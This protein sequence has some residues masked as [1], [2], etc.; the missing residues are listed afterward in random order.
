MKFL[1]CKDEA[2]VETVKKI[3]S[4]L[5]TLQPFEMVKIT[6]PYKEEPA[7]DFWQS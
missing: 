1:Y 5:C 6:K 4:K 7:L 2:R 3:S